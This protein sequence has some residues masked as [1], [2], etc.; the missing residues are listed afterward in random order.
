MLGRTIRYPGR[1]ELLCVDQDE[2]AIA[3]SKQRLA[4]LDTRN[5]AVNFIQGNI[6]R[7]D[8]LDVGPDDGL[9]MVYSIGIADY[10]QDRMLAK[11]FQDSF[12][13]LRPGGKL[14]VAYKDRDKNKPLAFNWYVD[15]NFIPRNEAELLALIKDALG[16]SRYSLA[17][18]REPTGIIFFAAITKA[19]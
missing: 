16:D 17:V 5:I 11:I 2:E 13:K 1:V 12:K 18:E 14:V 8:E 19:P 3:Y 15:W 4:E 10:L 7:L 9:D 6:L